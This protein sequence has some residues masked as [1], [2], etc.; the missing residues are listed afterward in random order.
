MEGKE[1]SQIT[2]FC[3]EMW[4]AR[5]IKATKISVKISRKYLH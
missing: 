1:D 5:S 4:N 2:F 3:L